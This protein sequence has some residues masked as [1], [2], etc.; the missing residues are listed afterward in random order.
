MIASDLLHAQKSGCTGELAKRELTAILQESAQVLFPS[1][2]FGKKEDR[3]VKPKAED[4]V[5]IK[6]T[7]TVS[8]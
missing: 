2:S 8:F 1:L 7:L 5:W 6:G 3:K 4:T